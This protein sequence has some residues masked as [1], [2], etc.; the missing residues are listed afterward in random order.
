MKVRLSS[1]AKADIDEYVNYLTGKT[2]SGIAKFRATLDRAIS[3]VSY[4]PEAGLT[5]SRI[6]IIGARRII[7]EGWRFDYDIINDVVLIQRI[8]HSRN[9]PMISIAD[10]TDYE[11]PL[12]A[13]PKRKY[14]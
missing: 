13:A 5:D 4:Q 3:I 1:E 7:V 8:T 6:P 11:A 2:I 9:T 10:D 14:D 12:D